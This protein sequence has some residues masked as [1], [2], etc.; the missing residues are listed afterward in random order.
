MVLGMAGVLWRQVGVGRV[1]VGRVGVGRVGGEAGSGWGRVGVGAVRWGGAGFGRVRGG[2][3]ARGVGGW[4]AAS[5]FQPTFQGGDNGVFFGSRVQIHS[6][7]KGLGEVS[8]GQEVVV[9][10]VIGQ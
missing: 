4:L 6:L 7:V 1:G 3:L 10:G 2:W 5:L 9:V 8:A